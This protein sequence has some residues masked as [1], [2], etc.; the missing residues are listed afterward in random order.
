[1]AKFPPSRIGALD[2]PETLRV[3]ASAPDDASQ[4]VGVVAEAFLHDPTWSWA[5][6]DPATR[7]RWWRLIVPSAFRYPWV[8][9]TAG[10]EAVSVWIPPN[11]TELTAE[12]DAQTIALLPELVGARAADVAELLRRFVAAHPNDQP[13]YYLSLLTTADR[14]RGRGLGMALL[15]ENLARIDAE[16]AAAYLESTNPKNNPR[17]ASLGFAPV[18]SFEAPGGGPTVTGMWRPAR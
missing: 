14:H 11:G 10:F 2:A 17:Y 5:F 9:R 18:V 12:E 15:R 6:P 1:M 7:E 16:G 8:M 3:L 4:I 13:H